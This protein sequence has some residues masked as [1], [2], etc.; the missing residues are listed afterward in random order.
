MP[1]Y[2][3]LQA[4][5][6][7]KISP[8]TLRQIPSYVLD[9]AKNELA[10]HIQRTFRNKNYH[11][12]YRKGSKMTKNAM[13]RQLYNIYANPGNNINDMLNTINRI[14]VDDYNLENNDENQIERR[15]LA[16]KYIIDNLERPLLEKV[17]N[18]TWYLHDAEED[19]T[20]INNP[21]YFPQNTGGNRSKKILKNKSKRIKYK[22]KNKK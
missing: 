17:Y 7:R 4:K 10:K 1:P 13:R 18:Y 9:P 12:T 5:A 16:I 3:S 22:S 15:N 14:L 20:H 8:T 2:E 21:T 6:I 19:E 11:A